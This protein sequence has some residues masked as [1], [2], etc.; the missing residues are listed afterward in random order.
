MSGDRRLDV[1]LNNPVEVF[2]SVEH[3]HEIWKDDPFDVESVHHEAR[4]VFQNL[5]SRATTPQGLP[6]GRVL[7]LLGDSGAGKTHLVRAFRRD[8]H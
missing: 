3:R 4:D 7:L 8:T 2:H 6:S 1:F 5:L